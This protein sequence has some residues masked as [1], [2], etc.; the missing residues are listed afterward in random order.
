MKMKQ[1]NWPY[2]HGPP[3]EELPEGDSGWPASWLIVAFFV[4]APLIYFG[5]QLGAVEAWLID[6]Y[7]MVDQWV[8]PIRELFQGNGT[9]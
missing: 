9:S 6:F 4:V 7:R 5:P 3:P 8:V 2:E 1:D